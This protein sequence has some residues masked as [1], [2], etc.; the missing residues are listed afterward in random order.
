VITDKLR[1]T[2]RNLARQAGVEVKQSNLNSRSDLRLMHY[3]I[4]N[5]ISTVLDVGA[6]RGQFASELF[7][8]GFPGQIVSFEAIPSV[9]A[10]LVEAAASF[11]DRWRVAPCCAV[12][13]RV[14]K[15][16][17]HVTN[18]L[19]SSSL[20]EPNA[21]LRA[22]GAPL[23]ERETITVDVRRLDNVF[24][25]DGKTGPIFL[26][27]DVQGAE[28]LVLEGAAGL[29]AEIQGLLLEMTVIPLYEQQ[30]LDHELDALALSLGFEL[31]DR[32][33]VLRDAAS[34]RL[35]QYDAIYFRRTAAVN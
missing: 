29:L 4:V 33:P 20:F 5:G 6:N 34:A 19:A 16:Q 2:V 31:W 12:G 28:P 8:L 7:G 24:I 15:T 1:R 25:P 17:F 30:M 22:I 13:A 10:D 21:R 3:L 9:H 35:L 11:G 23:Q 32:N 27:V 26:K 18:N 14:G